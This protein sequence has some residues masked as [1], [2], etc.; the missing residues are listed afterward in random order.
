MRTVTS[1][2]LCGLVMGGCSSSTSPTRQVAQSE[3][4]ES[5]R[6]PARGDAARVRESPRRAE[7]EAA[8]P[9]E[10]RILSI[11]RS[12]DRE[13]V[14]LGRLAQTAGESDE[15]K[16][17]GERLERDHADHQRAVEA[18]ARS[19]GIDLMEP[20]VVEQMLARERGESAPQDPVAELHRL[21]GAKFDQAFATMMR[22]GHREVIEM[23]ESAQGSV[24]T[25]EVKDLLDRTLPTLRED[26]RIAADLAGR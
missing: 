2:V 5:A 9:A 26:E 21:S 12:K 8:R 16:Q 13:E 19:V 20:P 11:L 24:R 22:D 15:V 18:L 14:E 3:P 17:F 23:V 7:E 1:A 25:V 4:D 6:A 10:A